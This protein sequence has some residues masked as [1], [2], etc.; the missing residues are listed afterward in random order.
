MRIAE[1]IH[2]RPSLHQVAENGQTARDIGF[3]EGVEEVAVV[4]A[5]AVGDQEFDGGEGGVQDGVGEGRVGC[6]GVAREVGAGAVVEEPGD[7]G[8][9]VSGD[10]S[11]TWALNCALRVRGKGRLHTKSKASCN[12]AIG[13]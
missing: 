4:D 6:V 5:G 13:Y 9:T 10:G 11:A 7:E 2:R 1:L 12:D 8:E 3:G